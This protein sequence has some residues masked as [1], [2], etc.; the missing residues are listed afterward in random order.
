MLLLATMLVS[1]C[2]HINMIMCIAIS[3]KPVLCDLPREQ[4]NVVT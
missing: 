1:S 4:W 3:V 2:V